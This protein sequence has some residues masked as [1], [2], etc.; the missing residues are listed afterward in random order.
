MPNWEPKRCSSN[1]TARSI[2]ATASRSMGS[3]AMSF[4]IARREIFYNLKEAQIVI[5]QSRKHYTTIRPYSAVGYRPPRQVC[6]AIII[7]LDSLRKRNSLSMPLVYQN[8][9]QVTQS[10]T[11]ASMSAGSPHKL[12]PNLKSTTL[13]GTGGNPQ[14]S[15]S[16]GPKPLPSSESIKTFGLDPKW[17]VI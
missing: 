6:E 10:H 11:L 2:M 9:N 13:R 3:F 1:Q 16:R 7:P 5:E 4:S 8:I 14:N 17:V 12:W 15:H